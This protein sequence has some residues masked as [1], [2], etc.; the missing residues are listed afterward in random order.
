VACRARLRL[1]RERLR[2]DRV[3][4]ARVCT[5]A[6]RHGGRWHAGEPEVLV[7]EERVKFGV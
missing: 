6:F 2:P 4:H 1:G 3:Q 7:R 5:S